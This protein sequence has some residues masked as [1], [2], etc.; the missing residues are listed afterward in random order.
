MQQMEPAIRYPASTHTH[1][2]YIH[3]YIIYIHTYYTDGACL[4]DIPKA[5]IHT[6]YIHTYIIHTS[7]QMHTTDG[8]YLNGLKRNRE[9]PALPQA[10]PASKFPQNPDAFLHWRYFLQKRHKILP[11]QPTVTREGSRRCR[12]VRNFPQNFPRMR[13][14][15][16]PRL[17]CWRMSA[18]SCR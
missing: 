1:I 14:V 11:G 9:G 13:R 17:W 12:E 15:S 10:L 4:Q 6:Q 16:M 8:P 3:T 5:Y 2:I 18:H 7:T